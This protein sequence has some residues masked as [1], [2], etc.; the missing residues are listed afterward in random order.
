MYIPINFNYVAMH[1][2][3]LIYTCFPDIKKEGKTDLDE[4]VEMSKNAQFRAIQ[5]SPSI[6]AYVEDNVICMRPSDVLPL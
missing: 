5:P 6:L 1:S 3:E 4:K 2:L